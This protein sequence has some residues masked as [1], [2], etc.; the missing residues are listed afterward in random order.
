MSVTVNE[1][2]DPGVR[3]PPTKVRSVLPAPPVS[4][5]P[6]PQGGLGSTGRFAVSPARAGTVAARSSVNAMAVASPGAVAGWVSVNSSVTVP[7]GATGSSTKFFVS[8]G[9]AITCRSSVAGRP[10]RV[11]PLTVAVIGEVVFV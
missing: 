10:V 6:A 5:E 4:V 8:C 3:L 9:G 11:V 2:V 1:Q 7:P